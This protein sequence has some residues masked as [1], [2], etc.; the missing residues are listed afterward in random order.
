MKLTRCFDASLQIPKSAPDGCD[1]VLGYIG[2]N[3]LHVWTVEE[4]DRFGH[5]RQ[6]PSWV[7]DLSS[8]A[9]NQ[10]SDAVEAAKRLGW[11]PTRAIVADMEVATDA[12][13][14]NEW[15]E[16]VTSLHYQPAWYGSASVA[17]AY[18]AKFKWVADWDDNPDLPH[19]WAAKQYAA[20]VEVPGGVVDLS[21][22]GES[23]IGHGGVGA[24][25]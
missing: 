23:L 5:L 3:A 7:A 17:G 8:S 2:G 21:V 16:E 25:R 22:I 6:F 20:N 1:A 9:T 12:D 19:G 11:H 24:R 14:W 15:A 4:W 13:W 18:T 10:A